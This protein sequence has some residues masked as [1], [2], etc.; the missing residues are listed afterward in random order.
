MAGASLRALPWPR[1]VHRGK[2]TP[3]DWKVPK[4]PFPSPQRPELA[5][6]LPQAEAQ[7]EKNQFQEATPGLQA[8]FLP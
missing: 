6:S 3:C 8:T 1:P 7:S 5:Q 2:T 4:G